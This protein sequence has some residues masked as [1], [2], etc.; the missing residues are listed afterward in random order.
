MTK[1]KYKD[2]INQTYFKLNLTFGCIFVVWMCL[3]FSVAKTT[4][5]SQMSVR[6]SVSP[7]PKPLSLSELL[8]LTIKPINQNAYRPSSLLTIK[9]INLSSSFATFKPFGLFAYSF[10]CH[11]SFLNVIVS[12]EVRV[13]NVTLNWPNRPNWPKWPNWPNWLY[14]PEAFVSI[15]FWSCLDFRCLDISWLVLRKSAT[16]IE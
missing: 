12:Q 4:L 14:W 15:D 13:G 9:P 16:I 5:Q 10:D 7:L 3:S 2:F 1:I 8:L 6:L 11:Y